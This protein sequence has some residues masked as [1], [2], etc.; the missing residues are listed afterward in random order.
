MATRICSSTALGDYQGDVI[1]LFMSAEPLNF[2]DNG[3]NQRLR[4][5]FA[6]PLQ[7]FN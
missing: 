6:V 2:F 7:S 1:A 5:L 3:R 4:T